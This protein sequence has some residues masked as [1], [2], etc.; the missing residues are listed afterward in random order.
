MT[1][2]KKWGR[3]GYIIFVSLLY[4][5]LIGFVGG[6]MPSRKWMMEKYKVNN[7]VL[8]AFYYLYRIADMLWKSTL[9]K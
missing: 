1:D 8:L 2:G 4:D 9:V 3:V 5:D 6:V 7:P